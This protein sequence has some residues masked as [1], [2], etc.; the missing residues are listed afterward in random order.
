[1]LCCREEDD[2]IITTAAADMTAAMDIDTEDRFIQAFR[3][4]FHNVLRWEQFERLWEVLRNDA[5][6]G[7]YIYH[8]GD[9][10]PESPVRRPPV[11]S[12]TMA[13]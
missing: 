5:D 2:P 13:N 3:G 10:P 8:V 1:M 6:D 4:R 7:W 9:V 12:V 11:R